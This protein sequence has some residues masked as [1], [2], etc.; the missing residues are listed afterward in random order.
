[1]FVIPILLI[2][3]ADPTE[4]TDLS[5]DPDYTEIISDMKDRVLEIIDEEYVAPHPLAGAFYMGPSNSSNYEGCWASGWC[6]AV[7]IEIDLDD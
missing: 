4:T 3:S 6:D 2:L 1:M 7:T 5:E